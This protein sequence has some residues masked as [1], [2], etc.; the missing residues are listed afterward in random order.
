[1]SGEPARTG[2]CVYCSA[3]IRWSPVD[4][5]WRATAYADIGGY[6]ATSPELEHIPATPPQQES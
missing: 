3:H 6:C 5:I 2:T 1:M 4:R